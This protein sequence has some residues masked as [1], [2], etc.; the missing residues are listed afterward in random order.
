MKFFKFTFIQVEISQ[1]HCYHCKSQNNL[2]CLLIKLYLLIFYK[3]FVVTKAF[4]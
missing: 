3:I 2:K 4:K 1:T